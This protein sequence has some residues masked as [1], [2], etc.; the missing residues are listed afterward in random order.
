MFLPQN[1][2][3]QLRLTDCFCLKSYQGKGTQ[4]A[5][6]EGRQI[7]LESKQI[8]SQSNGKP[9]LHP[10]FRIIRLAQALLQLLKA[11]F[12]TRAWSA[13]S[14][15]RGGTKTQNLKLQHENIK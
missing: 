1:R 4:I 12:K 6:T 11:F 13:L 3:I 14:N 2:T 9:L 10:E 5:A 7:A 15:I 8:R